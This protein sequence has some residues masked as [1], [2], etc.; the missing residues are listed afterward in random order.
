[1]VSKRVCG[2]W[3]GVYHIVW[4]LSVG[5]EQL[6]RRTPGSLHQLEACKCW[7]SR[8]N[9]GTQKGQGHQRSCREVLLLL[10]TETGQLRPCS[11][12]LA[13][14]EPLTP[15][16]E[17]T[18]NQGLLPGFGRCGWRWA[19]YSLNSPEGRRVLCPRACLFSSHLMA[20]GL[21]GYVTSPK[22]YPSLSLFKMDITISAS[23]V[24]LLT[25]PCRDAAV[26]A[27]LFPTLSLYLPQ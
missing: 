7:G 9:P 24:S 18:Q 16:S 13:I 8:R 4:S 11:K 3:D 17:K 12:L 10:G 25:V 1:M 20:V 22:Y 21:I 27:A 26:C 19:L 5:K 23:A 15:C 2:L 14:T 6:H